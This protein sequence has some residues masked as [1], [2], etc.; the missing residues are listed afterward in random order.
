LN[1][2]WEIRRCE[3]PIPFARPRRGSPLAGVAWKQPP[4][5]FYRHTIAPRAGATALLEGQGG[6][7][8]LMGCDYGKGRVAVFSGT[9]LGEP[10]RGETAFWDSGAWPEILARTLCWVARKER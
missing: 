7:P 6:E 8:L 9:V 3:L 2:P 4:T 1:G 10:G 5:V